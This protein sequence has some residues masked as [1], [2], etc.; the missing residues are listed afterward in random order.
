MCGKVTQYDN[1]ADL[2]AI[3]RLPGPGMLKEPI[4]PRYNIAP[5][6]QTLLMVNDERALVGERVRWR[7][8]AALGQGP[9]GADQ[10]KSREGGAWTIIP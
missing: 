1:W 7:M 10:C 8:P 2:V 3:M 9:G 5:T 6:T 4:E